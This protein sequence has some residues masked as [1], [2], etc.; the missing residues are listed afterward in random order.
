MKIR[1]PRPK[2][3]EHLWPNVFV[4]YR[5]SGLDTKGHRMI[6][7]FGFEGALKVI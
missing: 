4:N 6:E 7:W 1:I 2:G 3:F 5:L